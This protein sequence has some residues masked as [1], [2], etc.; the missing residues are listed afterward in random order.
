MYISQKQERI[1]SLFVIVVL[2]L[3][4]NNRLIIAQQNM[5]KDKEDLGILQN[6]YEQ[7]LEGDSTNYDALTNLGV[8]YYQKGD[9][10]KSLVSFEQA[11][12]FHPQKPR[13]FHNLGIFYDFVGK[14]DVAVDNLN[15]AAELDSTSPNSVRQ[16][17]IIY[18]QNE[19]YEEAITSFNNALKRNNR[20]TESYLG[21]TLACWLLKDYNNVIA[22]INDM[23][24]FGLRFNRMELLLAD[25]YYKLKKYDRAVKYAK[26]DEQEN[27]AQ[28]EGHYLLGVLYKMIGEKDKAEFEFN[29]AFEIKEKNEDAR[30]EFDAKSFLKQKK[31]KTKR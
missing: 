24:S 16:L 4:A 31:A 25:V 6:F 30:F 26:I 23:Q 22:T 8:I 13:A 18:L 19:K 7:I 12:R 29:E 15:K 28:P 14:F 10:K 17:G 20:D 3:I 2:F 21:K 1:V 9:I 11:A 27:S 5:L